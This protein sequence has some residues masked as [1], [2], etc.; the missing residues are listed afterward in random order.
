VRLLT[1]STLFP[2]AADPTHGVFVENRL[3]HLAASGVTEHRVIAPVAWV[4]PGLRGAA[5][6]RRQAAA[7]SAEMRHGIPVDHPRFLTI[8]RVGMTLAP[9]LLY[10]GTVDAVERARRDGFDFD[11]IDAHYFYPDGVAATLLGRR[12][13]RPVVITARGTDVNVLPNYALP[14]RMIVRA[15]SAAAGIVTVSR[16]LCDSLVAL[17]VPESRIRVLRNGVDLDLFHPG[18][19]AQRRQALGLTGP[20]LLSVG[21]LLEAKGHHLAIEALASMPGVT[22]LIAGDGP[23]RAE[24]ES[25][26]GSRGVSDRVQFLGK[27]PHEELAGLYEAADVLVLASAR[28]GWPNVLLEAMA[29]G[30]PVVASNVG[31]IPE[32]VAAPEAGRMLPERTSAAI[33]AAVKSLF[34]APPDRAATRA[35][36]E[37]FGWDETT[38][39]QIALFSEILGRPDPCRAGP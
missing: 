5:R 2:N 30:T 6:Y 17:G 25:L 18:D 22:L 28:E 8:P 35:Y 24:L 31:G 12:F 11:L 14:R 37:R 36:A 10:T 7:P 3:R 20:T 33:A 13:R 26:V 27:S 21:N 16:A 29:C 1:F 19:R 39:G 9:F 32:V 38:R 15:A 4:P 34:A 23:F